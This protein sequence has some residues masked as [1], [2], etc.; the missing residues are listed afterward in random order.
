MDKIPYV[1]GITK[2]QEV[3]HTIVDQ[4]FLR[5]HL[6]FQTFSYKISNKN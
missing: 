5:F 1:S 6:D 2:R 3:E 4:T